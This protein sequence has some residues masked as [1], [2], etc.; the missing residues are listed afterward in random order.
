M[1]RTVTISAIVLTIVVAATLLFP[2]YSDYSR[3]NVSTALLYVGRIKAALDVACA[4]GT[5]VSKRTMGDLHLADSDPKAFVYRVELSRIAPDVVHVKTTFTDI[6]A[7]SEYFRSKIISQGSF[8]E[9]EHACSA[10]KKPSWRHVASTVE[11]K[12]LPPP[13]RGQ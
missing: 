5:F 7:A 10:D 12:Y 2:P 9:F 13:W 11:A 8:L 3:A 4:E 6:Y 1:R